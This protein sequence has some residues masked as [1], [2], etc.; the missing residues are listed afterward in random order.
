[1]GVV[2]DNKR[3]ENP[4]NLIMADDGSGSSV[5]I[6]TFLI[7][8]SDGQ[9]LIQAIH[10]SEEIEEEKK[11][12]GKRPSY[13][14]FVIIQGNVDISTKTSKPIELDMWYSS[15]YE[16]WTSKFELDDIGKMHRMLGK[17]VNFQPR[18]M[19]FNCDYCDEKTKEKWCVHD[20]KY[21]PIYPP[22]MKNALK[23]TIEPMNLL[24]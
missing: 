7:S 15:I 10:H 6:P 20:G 4:K 9:K 3:F 14:N 13:K 17:R 22:S 11:A 23:E 2:I 12:D 19:T 24:I 18:T 16:L 21:C 8:Y 5:K 1:M